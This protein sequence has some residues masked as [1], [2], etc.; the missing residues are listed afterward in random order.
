MGSV[1]GVSHPIYF[2]FGD[3]RV[4]LCQAE[5]KAGSVWF[6]DRRVQTQGLAYPG[7]ALYHGAPFLV[8]VLSFFLHP[9]GKVSVTCNSVLSPC[10]PQTSS[11][12]HLPVLGLQALATI[13]SSAS[14][15]F[16]YISLSL[17]KK[18]NILKVSMQRNG[19]RHSISTCM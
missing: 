7:R 14:A 17:K 6:S 16:V 10:W 5:G 8:P 13:P 11:C 1:L 12:F 18:K 4:R 15:L 19:F 2:R 3:T 9:P